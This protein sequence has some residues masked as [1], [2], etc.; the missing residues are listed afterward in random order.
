MPRRNI[1]LSKVARDVGVNLVA[2]LLAAVVISVVAW[3]W[4]RPTLISTVIAVSTALITT[5]LAGHKIIPDP[6]IGGRKGRCVS[7][8]R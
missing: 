3:F 1:G 5:A 6:V 2:N 4:T 8:S 7:R